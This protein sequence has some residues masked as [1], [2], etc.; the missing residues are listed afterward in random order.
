M[1]IG[2]H[3]GGG[4]ASLINRVSYNIR[5]CNMQSVFNSSPYFFSDQFHLNE[6]GAQEFSGIINNVIIDFIGRRK[7]INPEIAETALPPSQELFL[8]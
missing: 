6:L 1:P 8:K 3:C 4:E 2:G 7:I 5:I